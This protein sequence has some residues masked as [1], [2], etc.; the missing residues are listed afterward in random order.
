MCGM[1]QISEKFGNEINA[2]PPMKNRSGTNA[3]FENRPS[4]SV[5]WKKRS[6]AILIPVH[7]S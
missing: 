6:T 1:S 2:I 7:C 3:S 5:H 4:E